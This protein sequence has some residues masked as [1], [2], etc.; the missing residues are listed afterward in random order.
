[1]RTLVVL[2]FLIAVP[3]RAEQVSLTPPGVQ[4]EF[5]AY[6]LGLIPFDG[7]FTRFHGWFRYDPG[8]PEACQVVL[9]I[10]AASLAMSS[11]AIRDI[12]AGAE[13]MDVSRF[14]E[15][16]FH[17]D[18]QGDVITG[19]LL[20]HGENHPFSLELTRTAQAITATGKLQRSQWGMTARRFTA[21]S[22]IRI[23]VQIPNPTH[24]LHT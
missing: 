17:G 24:G 6:G 15:L 21:G 14:P 9:E 22:T 2:L 20:L 5:R 12:T 19:N 16:A 10:D 4:V 13:F 8:R 1:M 18:C 7:K 11:E 23:R 3:A